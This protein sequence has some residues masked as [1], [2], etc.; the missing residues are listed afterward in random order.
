[1]DDI[2]QEKN[3]IVKKQMKEGRN[4]HRRDVYLCFSIAAESPAEAAFEF[5]RLQDDVNKS[6][7]S[8]HSK[9]NNY[10][11]EEAIDLLYGIYNDNE[12]LVK[13]VRVVDEEGNALYASSFDFGR[14]RSMGMEV[15]DEIAPSS[16]LIRGDYL[17]IGSRYI[18]VLKVTKLANKMT[19]EFFSKVTDTNFNSLTTIN[20]RPID[21]RQADRII[22]E[23]L[24]FVRDQKTKQIKA[25]QKAG[26]FDDSFISPELLDREAQALAIRDEVKTNDEHL[27]EVT[28]S[29]A[30]FADSMEG[31]KKNCDSLM[32]EY[33]KNSFEI[34]VLKNQQLEGFNSTL[35]L[36]YNQIVEKRT[37]TSSSLAMFVPFDTVELMDE[38]GY[39]YGY[40]AL[41][42]KPLFY[43]PMSGANYNSFNLGTSGSGKSVL[44]KIEEM[45]VI[46]RAHGVV[47]I[48][49]PENEAVF[50]EEFHPQVINIAPGEENYF[51]AMEI[52]VVEGGSNDI[53]YIAA[54]SDFIIKLLSN[55]KILGGMTSVMETIIDECVRELF[56]P[57]I[58][59][60]KL[61]TIPQEMM[62]TLTDLM[63]MLAK[64][65]EPEAKELAK[66][67]GI[68][69]TGSLNIF[70]KQSNIDITSKL[71]VFRIRDIGE[72]L[73]PM[74]F[75]IMLDHIWNI[76]VQNRTLGINTWYIIDEIYLLFKNL[77]ASEML[78]SMVKRNRK[79]GGRFVGITQN[80][81]PLLENPIARDMLQ[82]CSML[83]ILNQLGTDREN[84]KRYLNMSDAN[85]EYITNS[86][87]GQ[88]IIYT[89]K[90]VI[91]FRYE[92]PKETKLYRLLT[93]NP[94][95]LHEY[96]L[97]EQREQAR[98]A[99]QAKNIV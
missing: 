47:I 89:G 75:M 40:N 77:Y 52:P 44:A 21:S 2:R 37:L 41:S 74:A 46:L 18:R 6:L 4:G 22:A 5:E 29:V 71:I 78:N 57:F 72:E 88:G 16:M 48:I 31:L 94:K 69:T 10:P 60:G 98:L 7:V 27:F 58:M 14:M 61:T 64:R 20:I 13:K 73:K 87:P 70:G 19:D 25:G 24:S 99:K 50:P 68:Y 95:E 42:K 90:Q 59:D 97:E 17:Q 49:D 43:N 38:T 66:G 15:N 3:D 63:I 45:E 39:Y 91:P 23:N 56:A 84:L 55:L 30:V 11:T 96:E 32:A 54:K 9:L 86:P 85:M 67:M 80:V 81:T 12:H 62:P 28:I 92:I 8:I 26:V 76:M 36:C 34:S 1:M 33:K 93:T 82:N 83:R 53:D 65:S 51:N 79:Y 35:P